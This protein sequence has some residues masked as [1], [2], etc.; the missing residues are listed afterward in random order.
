[1]KKR[2]LFWLILAGLL[3]SCSNKSSVQEPEKT[4]PELVKDDYFISEDR[5]EEIAAALPIEGK[6]HLLATD[7]SV[8]AM[9]SIGRERERERERESISRRTTSLPVRRVATSS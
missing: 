6:L 9:R 5:A 1:M 2:H 3:C 8:P 4:A 7:K